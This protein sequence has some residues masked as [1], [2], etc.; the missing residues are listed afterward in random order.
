MC[1]P[2][3]NRCSCEPAS[4]E[5]II[6][7]PGDRWQTRRRLRGKA[8][9]LRAVAVQ[10]TG[11]LARPSGAQYWTLKDRTRPAPAQPTRAVSQRL[12]EFR[13]PATHHENPYA[14]PSSSCQPGTKEGKRHLLRR[15]SEFDLTMYLPPT[16]WVKPKESKLLSAGQ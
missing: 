7:E 5:V 13:G 16:K 8:R 11:G 15:K 9:E 14:S 4:H 3:G 6:T 1:A 12:G 10:R 2:Q